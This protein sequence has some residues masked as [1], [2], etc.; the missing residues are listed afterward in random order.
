MQDAPLNIR[1][2]T[3]FF[4]AVELFPNFFIQILGESEGENLYQLALTWSKLD[5]ASKKEA[6]KTAKELN[7]ATST[8]EGPES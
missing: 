5:T 7:N 6:L 4:R 8:S 2:A 3:A 1:N